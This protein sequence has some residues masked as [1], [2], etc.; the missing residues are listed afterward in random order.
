[1]NT[2]TRSIAMD[3]RIKY[4]VGRLESRVYFT[5]ATV[6]DNNPNNKDDK[7]NII[8]SPVTINPTNGFPIT[9]III[10][11]QKHVGW[12]FTSGSY[13]PSTTPAITQFTIY[14]Q[15]MNANFAAKNIGTAAVSSASSNSTLVLETDRKS[16]V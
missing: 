4:G 5:S 11:G 1:M 15:I 10:G 12:D 14:D 13:T 7:G 8:G 6:Q 3:K 9:G 2:G 16:V